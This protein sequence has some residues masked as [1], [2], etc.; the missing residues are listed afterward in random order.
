MPP[1][2]QPILLTQTGYDS[3]INERDQLEA[4]RPVTV[5]ELSRAR[6]EGD[7]SENAAYKALKWK[8]GG[9]DK[10]LR[11]LNK[12]ILLAKIITPKNN[13]KIE[14]GHTVTLQSKNKTL[15]YQLVGS[16][17]ADPKQSK[18]SHLSPLGQ[19]LRH[20]LKGHTVSM[21]TPKGDVKYT[22]LSID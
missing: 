12:T 10:R 1:K 7:R 9:I 21:K 20:K 13:Q 3:L 22:I 18:I 2:L 5:K 19:A 8:L 11:Y 6:D 16:L 14:I 15:S 17:E 4:D